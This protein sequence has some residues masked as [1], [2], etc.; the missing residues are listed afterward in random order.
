[1]LDV[2]S[3]P[4]VSTSAI[5][6]RRIT[7]VSNGSN[8]TESAIQR[9]VNLSVRA[10]PTM[11]SQE[12]EIFGFTRRRGADGEAHLAGKSTRY[13]AIVLLGALF[14]SENAQRQ[15]CCGQSAYEFC[16]QMLKKVHLIENLGDAAL[17]SWAA[18]AM[19]HADSAAAIERTVTLLSSDRAFTTVEAAWVLSAMTTACA[20]TDVR[21]E[22]QEAYERLISTF[23]QDSGIFPHLTS[24]KKGPWYRA[25]VGCFADQVYP[26]QA[27]AKYY[28]LSG[29]KTALDVANRCAAQICRL[30]GKSGQWWWHYDART[31]HVVE[32]Y[33]VYSVH[34][35]AMAPMALL[36]LL[37][38]GGANHIESIR[39][40]ID[41]LIHAPEIGHSLIDENQGLIWRKVARREPGKATRQLRALASSV[42]SSWHLSWINPLVPP[43]K[44]DYECRPYHL[45]WI[46]HTWLGGSR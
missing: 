44:I 13:S 21:R 2:M 12:H 28:A 20:F 1:M 40:G 41:W 17:L 39:R 19:H 34:Q 7:Q 15:V 27:L 22:S 32:G 38:A 46:L 3:K 8:S 9:M 45:G 11:Y 26:I 43:T 23:N 42:A 33:P 31:G 5:S 36:D 10:L 4:I 37:D 35:D 29:D 30:Q 25:H 16:S 18:A 6:S 24:L 14:L